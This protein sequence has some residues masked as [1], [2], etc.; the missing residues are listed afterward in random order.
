MAEHGG[1]RAPEHPAP[2]SGPGKL[3]QRT[4]GGPGQKVRSMTD[5][6]YGDAGALL[7]QQH[8]AAMSATPSV[9]SP[10]PSQVGDAAQAA[11]APPDFTRGSELPSQP[12]TAGA[13]LGA[14]PGPSMNLPGVGLSAA[15]SGA[16][17]NTLRALSS[18]D[19]T[20]VLAAL[21]D[22]ASERGV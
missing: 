4:D 11:T 17:T 20:G 15:P 21:L 9:P 12:I 2:A 19:A 7:Q 22:S 1:Y 18:R 3:S 5:L 14:G 16:V 13:A 6:P 8:G 10:A